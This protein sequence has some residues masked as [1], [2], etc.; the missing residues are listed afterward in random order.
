[1]MLFKLSL[2]NITKSIKDYAIYFFTLVLGVAIF[3]VFNAID[4]Q[5]VMLNV[6]SSKYEAI[7]LMTTILGGVSVFVSFILGFLII[8]ASRFLIKRRNKEFG[9]YLT[10]GMP[11]RKISLIL[12]FETLIIGVIS[13]GVGLALGT[14]LSQLM[15]ILVANMFEADLT[16]FQFTFSSSAALKALLYFSIMYL[17]VMIFNTIIVN[18]CKLIDLLH[19]N[20]KS[21]KVKLKNPII[22]TI[23]FIIAVIALSYAY[24]LV[25]DGFG[26]S[27]LMNTIR[28]ILL[29]IALGCVSTFLIFW[30]L[31]GLILKIVMHL[32][33]YYYK[34]L[35]SFTVRQIS[36]KINTTVFSMTII[37]LM[38]FF[39]ICI[40][41]SALSIKN[42]LSG[43]LKD[44]APVD[45][46]FSKLQQ[47]SDEEEESFS[48]DIIEDYNTTA[49]DTL[50]RLDVYKYLKDVVDI[51]TYRVEEITLKDSFGDQ[52]EQIG[53]DYPLLAYQDKETLIKLSDYNRLAK[54]YNKKELTLKDNEYVIIS[55][56]KM[57]ADIRNIALKNNTK[58]TI[59]SKNY[60]PKYQECQDGFIE[61]SGSA[62]NTG[63]IILPDNALEG[64]YPYKN[65]LAAN[66]QADTKEE[67]EDIEETVSTIMNNHFNKDTLLTYNTKID[68]YASS[69]GL[70]AMVTF[71]GLYLGIIFLISSAAILAL[72]ELSESTDNKE[73]FNMLRK[74]GTDEKMINKALF[75]QIA[76]F[77][78]FPLLLAIIHSIF[79]IEFANYILKTMGTESLLSSIILTA[80]FL[81][82]I[83]GGYF[84]VTYYCSK[85]IIKE[86]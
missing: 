26:T 40:F 20:K 62:T 85:T 38:L 33:K 50:Q 73:R 54:L 10:L 7:E 5:T 39:T 55:N 75:N 22:C 63:V 43:N 64:I 47:L 42:S 32:K 79:G 35:N 31:S 6:S 67:K 82:V 2:K 70:G 65:V 3:Y 29:P 60:Y 24:Y 77:F 13:L 52:I 1:M 51:N 18:K 68:I 48:K 72:K 83:Y 81:V 84:L 57:M 28:G 25:T 16:K 86:R 27:P 12:F 74:I 78:L 56:Y 11:K 71:V 58:L 19:G 34:G 4:S 44:L 15:S 17:I 30:S 9:I 37:C 14:V 80:V 66:Y 8:Y 45:I 61:L 59:N 41:S 76:V 49:K 53:K 46:Q 36:S 23:V 21:E 69:I